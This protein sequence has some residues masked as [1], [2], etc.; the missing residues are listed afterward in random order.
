MIWQLD[1][2]VLNPQARTVD[3]RE[4]QVGVENVM[5]NRPVCLIVSGSRDKSLAR[6]S[7][8]VKIE[9]MQVKDFLNMS[10]VS[11]GDSML[12]VADDVL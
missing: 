3:Q 9:V 4:N 7:A 10:A 1:V 6:A 2:Q 12:K 5:V 8:R 11:F